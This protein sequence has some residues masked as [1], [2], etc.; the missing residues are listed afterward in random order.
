M[1]KN[2]YGLGENLRLTKQRRVI[3]EILKSTDTHPTADWIYAK[4]RK[5]IK[6]V[7]LGTIY[8]N[9]NLLTREN[10][11]K[12][13]DFGFG[14]ARFDGCMEH[15]SHLICSSCG[16]IIDLPPEKNAVNISDLETKTG[17]SISSYEIEFHGICAKCKLDIDQNKLD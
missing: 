17:Y 3:L 4:A 9:L 10:L 14:L 1:E 6:N 5:Q 16:A 8:R 13:F 15:H 7:S 11:I 12:K 2:D